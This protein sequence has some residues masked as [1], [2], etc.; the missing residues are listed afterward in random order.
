M[1]HRVI[2]TKLD[3]DLFFHYFSTINYKVHKIIFI[4]LTVTNL[5]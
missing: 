1:K 4:I 5:R 3:N 2:N